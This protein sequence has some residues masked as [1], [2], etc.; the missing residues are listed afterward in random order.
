LG[1][2]VVPRYPGPTFIPAGITAGLDAS[3][4]TDPFYLAGD[5][6]VSWT[7]APPQ[8]S[9]CQLEAALYRAAD[10]VVIMQLVAATTALSGE[11][12]GIDT[13]AAGGYFMKAK[14]ECKWRVT[15][16]P[17]AAPE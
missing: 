10:R 7:L 17:L 4:E 3:G 2:I 16:T 13:L 12:S 6:A 14:S 8:D 5:Y 1:A 9:A 15:L 11:A